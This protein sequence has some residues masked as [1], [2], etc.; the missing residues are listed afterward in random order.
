MAQKRIAAFPSIDEFRPGTFR[1]TP[2][3]VRVAQSR[4]GQWWFIDPEG[5]PFV[6]KA[7][8]AVSRTGWAEGRSS[9]PGRYAA[10]V[11]HL[12]GVND[13][14]LFVRSAIQRLRK[15]NVNTLGAWTGADF[16]DQGAYYTELIEF[17]KVGP[18]FH[19]GG[20]LLPDV[21]DPAWRDA[22]DAWAKQICSPRKRSAELVGYFTDHELGWAQLHPEIVGGVIPADA[23]VE[24]PSLL[25]ICLSLEPSFRA[26]HAAWEFVLAPRNGDLESLARD[27]GLELPHREIIR[28]LTLAEKPLVS[29]SYLRDQR[30]FSREFARRYFSTCSAVIRAY[31]PHHLVLGCRFGEYPGSSVLAEC[32][33][34]SVD[35][36]SIR[37]EREG[38]D[39]TAQT[40][41]SSNGM[42]VMLTELTWADMAF[43]RMPTKREARR[44]TSV[45]RMLVKGRANLERLCAHRAVVGYEWSRWADS[46]EDEPPFGKGLVHVD[47][48]EAMEHTELFADVNARAESLRLRAK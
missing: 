21:F 40:C 28:Q 10:A 44:L 20:A 7:V 41:F 45:E 17:R 39:R 13:P 42:P 35:V 36:V 3:F 26:Y 23:K 9:R 2:G 25:Q 38:W 46:E 27:W 43:A 31:D 32:I 14:A 6:S 1:G 16:Y 5:R 48:R 8:A 12:Y 18:S 15:W 37:P 22:A 29:A 4:S 24:G 47:D 34:P 19:S 11:D 30:R 33:H